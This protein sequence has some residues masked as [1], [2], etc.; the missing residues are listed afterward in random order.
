MPIDEVIP[1][2]SFDFWKTILLVSATWLCSALVNYGVVTTKI[3]NIQQR[4]D[5]VESRSDGFVDKDQADARF[6][7]LIRRLDR[8]DGKVDAY[9]LQSR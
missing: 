9:F 3:E 7:E 6:S 2:K 1:T 4:V 8:L 5:R